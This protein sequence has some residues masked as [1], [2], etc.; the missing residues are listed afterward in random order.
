MPILQSFLVE[1]FLFD[2]NQLVQT[3][4]I[5]FQD[6]LFP[7]LLV[8][9]RGIGQPYENAVRLRWKGFAAI[10]NVFY[11]CRCHDGLPE[12]VGAVKETIWG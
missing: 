9:L 11:R 6:E 4:F 3:D 8:Q 7:G 2:G 1:G 5:R 10:Q 12:P